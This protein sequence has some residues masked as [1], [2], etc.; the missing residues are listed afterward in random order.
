M[1]RWSWGSMNENLTPGKRLRAI[2][3]AFLGRALDVLEIQ[4]YRA[5]SPYPDESLCHFGPLETL[6]AACGQT[7]ER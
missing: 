1:K 2:G 4:A 5:F 3:S 6:R 7:V